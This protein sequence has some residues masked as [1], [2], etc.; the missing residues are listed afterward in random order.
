MSSV[1]GAARVTM[2]LPATDPDGHAAEELREQHASAGKAVAAATFAMAI[3]SGAQALLYLRAFGVNGKT[4]A[5]FA[6]FALYATFGVFSQSLRVTAVPLLVGE[7]PRVSVREFYC[8]LAFIGGL[9]LIGTVPLAGPLSQVLAPGVGAADRQVAEQA[10]PLLGTAMVLVLWTAGAATLLAVRN[11]FSR[12]ASAYAIG[13][14]VG[15]LTFLAVQSTANELSLGWSMLATASVTFAIALFALRGGETQAAPAAT[16][17]PRRILSNTLML[18]GHTWV[19]LAFNG[20]YLITVAAVSRFEVGEAT[21]VSYAYLYAS[22]LVAGTGF[23]LGMTRISDMAR[24]AHGRWQTVLAD[25]VPSGFRYAMLIS[26][27]AIALLVAGGASLA[28]AIFPS[29]L[30]A[31]DVA[32]LQLFAVLLLPWVVAAQ[33]VNLLLPAMFAL[34]RARLVNLLA[35]P[36]VALQIAATALGAFLLGAPGAVGALAI[37]PA[38]FAIV[39]L[40][41]GAGERAGALAREMARDGLRFIGIAGVVFGCG[42]AV[43]TLASSQA[44]GA[45]LAIVIGSLLYGAVLARTAPR[46]VQMLT[47]RVGRAA[48]SA[49]PGDAA[50]AGITVAGQER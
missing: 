14:G 28:G 1:A 21:V 42:A 22:Y 46:Q 33:L 19:Y 23:A 34:G 31:H 25:T 48:T 29:S 13:A 47:G 32:L 15:L 20:L 26:A 3:A 35:I 45:M 4:D 41:N 36:L 18:L 37:A 17:R 6:A 16:P 24:G 39:L 43:A 2:A 10:L 9:V 38:A 11:R 8:S 7:R 49:S 44:I 5:F 40:V 50:V 12:I 27:P 30:S